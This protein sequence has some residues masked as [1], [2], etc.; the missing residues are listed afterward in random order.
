VGCCL[1]VPAI[2]FSINFIHASVTGA[3]QPASGATLAAFLILAAALILPSCSADLWRAADG[4]RKSFAFTA[5]AAVSAVTIVVLGTSGGMAARPWLL[6]H[7]SQATPFK[8]HLTPE[9]VEGR[10]VLVRVFTPDPLL[11]Q[12]MRMVLEGPD[13]NNPEHRQIPRGYARQPWPTYFVFPHPSPA[14]Q[15]WTDFGSAKQT[16][17]AFVLPTETLA[18]EAY[19]RLGS[20]PLED[21]DVD[22][23]KPETMTCRLFDVSDDEGRRYAGSLRFSAHL[24]RERHPRWA[25]V[26]GKSPTDSLNTL[27]LNWEVRTALPAALR[28]SHRWRDGGSE[29]MAVFDPSTPTIPV[30]VLL[31]KISDTRVGMRTKLGD[32]P[33]TKE[34]DGDY[35]ALA[36]EVRSVSWSGRLKTERD[37]DIELCRVA[38]SPVYLHIA[39][40]QPPVPVGHVEKHPAGSADPQWVGVDYL[41]SKR[42]RPPSADSFTSQWLIRAAR[43][44]YAVLTNPD[45]STIVSPLMQSEDRGPYSVSYT[46]DLRVNNEASTEVRQVLGDNA[47]LDVQFVPYDPFWR[48]VDISAAGGTTRRGGEMTL[49]RLGPAESKAVTVRVVDAMPLKG[50]SDIFTGKLLDTDG[51]PIAQRRVSIVLP[52]QQPG[53]PASWTMTTRHDGTC[54]LVLPVG[55]PFRVMLPRD[56]TWEGPMSQEQL[57]GEPGGPENP[58]RERPEGELIIRVDGDQVE[59]RFEEVKATQDQTPHPEPQNDAARRET[60]NPDLLKQAP[61]LPFIAWQP[62]DL[63]SPN[64]PAYRADGTLAD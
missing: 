9:A 18:N 40:P 45:G 11:T 51:K 47:T 27:E 14:T 62:R 52:D 33:N 58:P 39:D 25:E 24:V 60:S 36:D 35:T 31:Y 16:L 6:H 38:G 56:G 12:E 41:G 21:F 5:L 26:K 1:A 54:P 59:V 20:R 3:W 7:R 57:I 10:V 29:M 19:R 2:G 64:E 63:R 43:P 44:G 61:D 28:L 4:G 15:P 55:T 32:Q 48:W 46:V 49:H 23:Q 13:E 50:P 22:P 37:W 17:I 30:S 34:F 8:V 53:K 42:Q